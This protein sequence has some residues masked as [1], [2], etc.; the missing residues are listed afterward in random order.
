MGK[1]SRRSIDSV[2]S[3]SSI[4]Q[5]L[6]EE[7]VIRLSSSSY[8]C[9]NLHTLAQMSAEYDA[10]KNEDR[11]KKKF[12]LKKWFSRSGKS[13]KNETLKRSKKSFPSL[14]L[15][16]S[17]AKTPIL[18]QR[19]LIIESGIIIWE[20]DFDFANEENFGQIARICSARSAMT[21]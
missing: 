3:T 18:R 20:E 2:K 6:N 16:D 10:N 12:S 7:K 4:R 5:T 11:K 9:W 1:V 19:E 17:N 15:R 13:P 8:S 14:T 21:S